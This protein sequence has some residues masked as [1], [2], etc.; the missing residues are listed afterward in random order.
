MYALGGYHMV[1]SHIPKNHISTAIS[2][3]IND[4]LYQHSTHSPIRYFDYQ[5]IYHNKEMICLTSNIDFLGARINLDEPFI[6]PSL[7][8]GVFL[9][10]EVFPAKE[11]VLDHQHDMYTGICFV[12]KQASYTETAFFAADNQNK[13]CISFYLNNT[14]YLT[15]FISEFKEIFNKAISEAEQSKILIADKL[16]HKSKASNTV[17][18]AHAPVTKKILKTLSNQE[19]IVLHY[20]LKGKTQHEIADV[21]NISRSS[22]STFIHRIMQKF[23]CSTRSQLV[24][25]AWK[26]GLIHLRVMNN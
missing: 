11:I 4:M 7:S 23:G 21:M 6:E 2:P 16:L 19:T 9:A 1:Q 26:F 18:E 15:S 3:M 14:Q 25:L 20:L 12:K 10:D 8:E 24:E 22:V 13:N 5:R 17:W